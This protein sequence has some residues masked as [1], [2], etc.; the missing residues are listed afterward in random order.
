MRSTDPTGRS[1]E[2]TSLSHPVIAATSDPVM[3]DS[4]PMT[5]GRRVKLG[6]NLINEVAWTYSV[7][8]NGQ[9]HRSSSDMMN[10]RKTLRH[11]GD[12]L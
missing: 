3:A 1:V 9:S 11:D 7:T 5:N 6:P 4:F 8:T 2:L 12:T 10:V